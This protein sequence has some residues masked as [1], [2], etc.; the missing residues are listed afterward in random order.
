MTTKFDL[1]CQT[2]LNE[3]VPAQPGQPQPG[4]PNQQNNQQAQ[5]QN[6]NKAQ[7]PSS[8]TP[9][10]PPAPQQNPEELKKAFDSLTKHA[11]ANQDHLKAI[12][13]L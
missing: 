5:N 6:Q 13:A 9:P 7:H 8:S 3:T 12:A 11:G 10:A 2:I 4:Q 1:I